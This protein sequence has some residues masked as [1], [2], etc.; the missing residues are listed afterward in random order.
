M[1]PEN[2]SPDP[3][4]ETNVSDDRPKGFQ[5]NLGGWFGS[6][7]GSS[8]WMLVTPFFLNWPASGVVAGVVATLFIWSYSSLAWG[9]RARYSAFAGIIGLLCVT[10]VAN[11][12]FLIFAHIQTLPL[13]TGTDAIATNYGFYYGSL[14]IL[15]I[16]M[17]FLFWTIENRS[18]KKDA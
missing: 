10:V 1:E 2:E 17:I 18:R 15:V 5:W 6:T 8:V 11:L 14:L 16:S 9:F 12:G 7:L 3:A 13:D 4:D